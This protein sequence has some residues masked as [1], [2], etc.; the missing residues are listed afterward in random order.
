MLLRSSDRPA[1]K[2]RG[3]IWKEGSS[4]TPETAGREW[5]GGETRISDKVGGEIL[6]DLAEFSRATRPPANSNAA[7]RFLQSVVQTA[8]GVVFCIRRPSCAAVAVSRCC[9]PRRSRPAGTTG[10]RRKIWQQNLNLIR[11]RTYALTKNRMNSQRVLVDFR[12]QPV[13]RAGANLAADRNLT[14]PKCRH[15][16]ACA[17]VFPNRNC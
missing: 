9:H 2:N 11:L 10:H 12:K 8:A 13:W 1:R 17:S 16:L 15:I 7:E 5:G 6:H 4:E 14:P 3:E